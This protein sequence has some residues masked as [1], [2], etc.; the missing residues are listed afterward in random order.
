M[1]QPIDTLQVQPQTNLR[2][3]RRAFALSFVSVH[4]GAICKAPE[5]IEHEKQFGAAAPK[6][7]EQIPVSA[8]GALGVRLPEKVRTCQANNTW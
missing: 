8:Y 5:Q 7:A 4:R 6:A 3:V 1:V 2:L